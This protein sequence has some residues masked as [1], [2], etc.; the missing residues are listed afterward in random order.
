MSPAIVNWESYYNFYKLKNNDNNPFE[1]YYDNI[2]S[3]II[4]STMLEKYFYELVDTTD[5]T[6]FSLSNFLAKLPIN[7]AYNTKIF[8]EVKNGNMLIARIKRDINITT[9]EI[10]DQ[11]YPPIIIL[12][13]N[14]PIDI[15]NYSTKVAI[16]FLN[17]IYHEKNVN[18]PLCDQIDKIYNE[19][20]NTILPENIL[21]LKFKTLENCLVNGYGL[22]T[23]YEKNGYGSAKLFYKEIISKIKKYKSLHGNDFEL[24]DVRLVHSRWCK[25]C[26]SRKPDIYDWSREI[27]E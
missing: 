13:L 21:Q 7:G 10:T 26:G 12:R 23:V 22:L 25:H 17:S 16:P 19:M 20:F 5:F 18:C 3:T 9:I 14:L 1:F 2:N 27:D 24:D 4:A 11:N 6:Q 15:S 8:W